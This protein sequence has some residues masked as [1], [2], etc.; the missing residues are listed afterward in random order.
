MKAPKTAST[1]GN[2]LIRAACPGVHIKQ[3]LREPNVA[4]LHENNCYVHNKIARIRPGHTPLPI[5]FN[6]KPV[7]IFAIF[8]EPI[9]RVVSGYFHN[10]HDC[11][12]MQ[13]FFKINENHDIGLFNN[14]SQRQHVYGTTGV[15]P[16][17][18][19]KYARCVSACQTRMLLNTGCGD[20]RGPIGS[21]LDLARIDPDDAR[22]LPGE[23]RGM[24][25]RAVKRVRSEL[26][27]AGVT[28]RF[29]D[30]VRSLAEFLSV[31]VLPRI[32]YLNTRPSWASQEQKKAAK[33]VLRNTTLVDHYVYQA[34]YQRLATFKRVCGVTD[35]RLRRRR[36]SRGDDRGDD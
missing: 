21:D 15:E 6:G 29:K 7:A 35:R 24:V 27:F 1:F 28:E 25:K 9:S 22:S 5:S 34:A 36:L 23:A 31:P 13:G 12:S 20:D 18:L 19:Q 30:T 14:A 8:R 32:D 2:I 3:A 33:A 11:R 4:F 16:R 26:A 17:V 10:L